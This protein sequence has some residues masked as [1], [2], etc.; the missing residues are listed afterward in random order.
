MP[1]RRI[2]RRRRKETGPLGKIVL[3][4]DRSRGDR[5]AGWIGHE[6]GAVGEGDAQRFDDGVEVSGRRTR[7]SENMDDR[8]M[9]RW[10][11]EKGGKWVDGKM[12]GLKR[13]NLESEGGL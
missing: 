8:M 11:D 10:E 2:P 3:V 13:E 5:R 6:P 9:G 1:Q 4:Q 7:A 12:G